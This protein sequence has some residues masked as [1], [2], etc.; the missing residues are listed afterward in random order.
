MQRNPKPPRSLLESLNILREI[1]R[2]GRLVWKLLL[3]RRVPAGVKLIPLA[4]LVYIL[5]PIDFLPDV[6]L[7]LG[8]LDDL[9]VLILGL[10]MFLRMCPPGIVQQYREKMKAS[11]TYRA[12][13]QNN[14]AQSGEVDATCRVINDDQQSR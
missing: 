5:S 6:I 8:Q 1:I 14:V 3:D 4:V 12:A 9:T 13:E 2:Q 11:P 7:G 10:N